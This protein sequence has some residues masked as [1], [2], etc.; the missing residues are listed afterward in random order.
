MKKNFLLCLFM[1]AF[2]VTFFTACGDD[3][4]DK[5]ENGGGSTETTW[6]DG[7]GTYKKDGGDGVLKLNDAEPAA[8]KIVSLAASGDNAKITL[9]NVVPDDATVEFDNI[10]MKKADGNYTFESEKAVGTTTIKISGTL[11]GIPATKAYAAAK[12]LDIKV[13][14]KIT[15]PLAGTW[16]LNFD[17]K[18]GAD[19]YFDVSTDDPK[20]DA[21]FAYLG[22]KLGGMMAQKVT[23]V[24]A[25]FGED[26]IFDVNWVKQG[27]TDPTVLSSI[28]RPMAGDLMYFASE[29]QLFLVLDKAIL[30]VISV[31]AGDIDIDSLLKLLVDKGDYYALPMSMVINGDKVSFYTEKEMLNAILPIVHPMLAGL[32]EQLPPALA[33]QV[34]PLLEKLPEIVPNAEKFN[35]GL[36]FSK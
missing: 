29:S 12:T 16:K 27:E 7:A 22:P 24:S 32:G 33:G 19:V 26:G 15:S 8:T 14:R 6:K 31:L 3:D 10:E 5:K 17:E 34:G 20:N 9:T 18:T 30:P 25:I 23:A 11:S 36:N 21:A 4:D 13:T 35:V 2:S 28:T 1:M